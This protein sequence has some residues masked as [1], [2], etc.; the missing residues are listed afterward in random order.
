ME[1]K[2][3]EKKLKNFK[4]LK[5]YFIFGSIFFGLEVFM[6]LVRGQMADIPVAMFSLS[7]FVLS[8]FLFAFAYKHEIKDFYLF[9]AVLAFLYFVSGGLIFFVANYPVLVDRQ[10]GEKYS[11]RENIDLPAGV[12]SWNSYFFNPLQYELKNGCL[13]DMPVTQADISL[14]DKRVYFGLTLADREL[15]ECDFLADDDGERLWWQESAEAL[16][17]FVSQC[18]GNEISANFNKQQQ[19]VLA[20]FLKCVRTKVETTFPGKRLFYRFN[21]V[22]DWQ[23]IIE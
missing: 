13:V 17:E 8:V 6:W 9:F 20:E 18:L 23:E 7:L 11:L 19:I 15:I 2:K 10:T 12:K 16:P 22:L 3:E 14:L 5:I 4:F 1:E 21:D